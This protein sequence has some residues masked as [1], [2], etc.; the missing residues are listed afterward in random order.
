[1]FSRIEQGEHLCSLYHSTEEMLEQV[2]PYIQ[3]GLTHGEQCIYVADEHSTATI[4]SA[5]EQ[6]GIEIEHELNRGRF[7]VWTRS[8]YRQ[9]GSFDRNIMRDF[10]QRTL[11]ETL[12][13]GY[14]GVRLAVEMTWTMNCGVTDEELIRWEDF[15]NTI[16]YPGSNVSFLCQYNARLFS[17]TLTGM[18]VEVHPSMVLK[19]RVCRNLHYRPAEQVLNTERSK[20]TLD[21]LLRSLERNGNAMFPINSRVLDVLPVAV[22]ICEAPSGTIRYYNEQ[23]VKLWKRDPAWFASDH[24]FCAAHRV[25]IDGSCVPPETSPMAV[26][27]RER[28][29]FRNI[30]AE[31]ERPDG[32]RIDVLVNI[33]PIKDEQGR[34][35]GAINVFQDITERRRAE[36]AITDLSEQLQERVAELEQFHDAVV[37]R[38]L[39]MIEVEHENQV[40]KA[41]LADYE[42]RRPTRTDRDQTWAVQ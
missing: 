36:A 30:I 7:K 5:L 22:Y 42:H 25:F 41:K 13:Q 12:S 1:M 15:I 19:H 33:G 11:G 8:Q 16:S 4:T 10:I 23:A 27:V 39:R 31:F 26:C 28:K 38:E 24:Q 6:A 17:P 9:P 32:S 40:L 18:A 3:S 34:L 21:S 20:N 14:N 37:G 2:V 29:S 35:I